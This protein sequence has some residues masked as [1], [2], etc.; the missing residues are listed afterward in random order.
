M[1]FP[2]HPLHRT[3]WTP[4]T[5]LQLLYKNLF[6]DLIIFAIFA[7]VPTS[8]FGA[9]CT[10]HFL[11]AGVSFYLTELHLF[12]LSL[13]FSIYLFAPPQPLTILSNNIIS[14][15]FRFANQCTRDTQR[16][17]KSIGVHSE[18]NNTTRFA[19]LCAAIGWSI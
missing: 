11:T 6:G 5:V 10:Q 15:I 8:A 12:L 3:C 2:K 16:Q 4:S 13:C 7:L 14:L 19:Q 1:S 17:M 18:A 9:A